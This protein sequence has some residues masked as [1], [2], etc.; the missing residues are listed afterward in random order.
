MKGRLS[1]VLAIATLLMLCGCSSYEVTSSGDPVPLPGTNS[2]SLNVEVAFGRDNTEPLPN[3]RFSIPG[4]RWVTLEILNATGHRVRLLIDD[5]Y[6][7]GFQTATWD[8]KNDN[9]EEI[10]SGIYIYRL[11]AGDEVATKAALFCFS[12]EDCD[13]MT[14]ED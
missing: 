12:D 10:K 2:I 11:E 8:L 1:L 4:Y 3:I 13:K 6:L 14:S 5:E 7:G 9:G